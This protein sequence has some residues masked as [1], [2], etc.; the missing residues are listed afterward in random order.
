MPELPEVQ[1]VV[2]DLKEKISGAGI[3][4]MKTI[5]RSIWR[6]KYPRKRDIIGATVSNV[7]RRGKFILVYLSNGYVIIVHL[8]MTGRLTVTPSGSKIEKHTHVVLKFAGFDL[9]YND[10][11]RFGFMDLVGADNL[12]K[13]PYLH[14]LGPDPFDI[15]GDEF[16]SI[17]KSKNRMIKPLLLDQNVISGLGNIYS[18]E[19]LF[20]AR[21]HPRTISSKMGRKRLANLHAASLAVLRDAIKARGSSISNYVDGSGVKGLYQNSHRVYGREGEPCEKCGARI[22]REIIGSR[23]AHFCPRCQR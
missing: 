19:V 3:L 5:T 4:D 12:A 18:D 15:E 6:Y 11:R 10:I 8:G 23:S 22:K 21:I 14:K 20:E 16:I 13:I 1:T 9:H 7:A 2:D 17:I